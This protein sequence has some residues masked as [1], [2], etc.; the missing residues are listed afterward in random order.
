MFR[1]RSSPR[2][3]RGAVIS[4]SRQDSR[5]CFHQRTSKYA[6]GNEQAAANRPQ[7]RAFGGV[8]RFAVSGD[9]QPE[10]RG[11]KRRQEEQGGKAADQN[12]AQTWQGFLMRMPVLAVT[13]ATTSQLARIPVFW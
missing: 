13:V 6:A 3:N 8:R 11:R 7:L 9:G 5:P 2:A 4:R 1:A 12:D 10:E